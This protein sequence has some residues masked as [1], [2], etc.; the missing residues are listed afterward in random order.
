ML[1]DPLP[2]CCLRESRVSNSL[3]LYQV[4]FGEGFPDALQAR[5]VVD[6]GA[7]VVL[8]GWDTNCGDV[9]AVYMQ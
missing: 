1:R 5:V 2:S 8:L 9:G 3:S 6:D 4:M 7:A